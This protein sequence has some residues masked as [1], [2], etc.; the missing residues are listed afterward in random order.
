[1]AIIVF[2]AAVLLV[3]SDARAAERWTI[4]LTGHGAPIEALSVSR[5]TIKRVTSS[6][7]K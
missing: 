3:A 4:G 2:L 7:A 6:H 1:V 5:D